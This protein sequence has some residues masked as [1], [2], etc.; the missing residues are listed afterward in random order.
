MAIDYSLSLAEAFAQ[1]EGLRNMA[2]L[3]GNE[4]IDYLT[5]YQLFML[6][7]P[8]STR[9]SEALTNIEAENP[10]FLNLTKKE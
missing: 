7:D 5:G 4:P 10:G 1:V 9:L 8:I 2:A 6:L 3:A